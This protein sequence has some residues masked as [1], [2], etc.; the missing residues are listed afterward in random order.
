[1]QVPTT[2][3]TLDLSQRFSQEPV[4][5]SQLQ[6][7][8]AIEDFE[9]NTFSQAV[10]EAAA[11]AAERAAEEQAAAHQLENQVALQ[12]A[13]E[14]EALRKEAVS[15]PAPDDMV[16][17]SLSLSPVRSASQENVR[18]TQISPVPSVSQGDVRETQISPVPSASQGDV[19]ETQI[20][21]VPSASQGDVR[22]TQIAEESQQAE[23]CALETDEPQEVGVLG[24]EE[25][26]EVG[27]L[28]TDEPKEVGVLGTDE[29]NRT[30]VM[31]PSYI[32]EEDEQIC[33]SQ[34][35]VKGDWRAKLQVLVTNVD[36]QEPISIAELLKAGT[37]CADLSHQ[38]VSCLRQKAI[39][40]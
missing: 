6:A 30:V 32:D 27:V 33:V 16:Q 22:E 11:G 18:E 28:G 15:L 17:L 25:P 26:K 14:E 36:S 29:L 24:T 10:D 23:L 4:Q 20:S 37:L 13:A 31:P 9:A 39:H 21:P 2:Y 3:T 8:Q 19:R 7:S 40:V 5:A 12:K 38:L 1:M 34:S 35:T